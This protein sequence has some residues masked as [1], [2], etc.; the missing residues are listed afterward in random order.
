LPN[1]KKLVLSGS[2][3]ALN[4]LNVTTSV[5][6]ASFTGSFSGSVA[7]PGST[8]QVVYNGGG[9]LSADAG[10]VYSGSRLGIG[11]TSPARSI[12]VES[13]AGTSV[14]IRLNSTGTGGRS[15]SFFSTNNGSGLGGGKF[16]IYDDTAQL[17]R[18]VL[19][20]N[21]NVGFATNSTTV[22]S[23]IQIL[24]A[25]TTSATSTINATDSTGA[26]LL[27]VRDDGNVG[28]G[29]TSPSYK[30]SVNGAIGIEAS[31]EYLYFHSSATVGSNARAKIRAVG[32]GGG[33]GFGGDLRLSSRAS[34]NVWNEDVL[35]IAN[36]GNVG[37]GTIAPAQKLSLAVGGNLSFQNTL[38]GTGTYGAIFSYNDLVNTTTPATAIKFVRDVAIIGPDGAI[39]FD[40]NN[41]ER[42]RITSVG[43]VL[44]GTTADDT[45]NKLQVSG[46]SAFGANVVD[47]AQNAW[48]LFRGVGVS[49]GAGVFGSYGGFVLNSNNA[50]TGGARRYL[51]TN[52]LDVNKFAIIRSVDVS[53]TPT[54][55][56]G[57][58]VLSGF[59]D[60]SISNTGAATFSSSVTAGGFTATDSS[61][62][63]SPIDTG[64]TKA[65][66]SA[67]SIN[68]AALTLVSDSIGRTLRVSA[69]TSGTVIGAFDANINSV[70]IGSNTSSPLVFNTAGSERMRITSGGNVLIGT[71]T[72]GGEKLQVNGTGRF[73]GTLGIRASTTTSAATQ[74][75]VFTAD[76]SGTTRTLVTRT[77]AELRSDIGA[78]AALTNPVTGSG[79]G[80]LV[81]YWVDNNTITGSAGFFYNNSTNTL[82][83]PSLVESSAERFKTNISPLTGSLDKIQEMQGVTFYRDNNPN[84][85]EIGFIADHVAKIYPELIS[86]DDDNQIYGLQYPRITAILVEGIKELTQQIQNQNIF[87]QDL[88]SRIEGLENK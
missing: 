18:I 43:N 9:T 15:Y 33:S 25:G 44:I 41:T 22:S 10:L 42:L 30:L 19:D 3:A 75:P 64:L 37:I 36:T 47:G 23:R 53:T 68:G 56:V 71:T 21:G 1:W 45:I 29:I 5:T 58:A 88:K 81:S 85:Q 49:D 35:T 48:S 2:D 32:A 55:G 59:V 76:P 24:G 65:Y 39:L 12:D 8:T 73:D 16:G 80:S 67:A 28:I 79:S 6:A 57:G 69:N 63:G 38:G 34:N 78:Q 83:V 62:V 46:A 84:H 7:A 54:L 4:S 74:I 77:P 17:G 26:S 51:I 52:A 31:E 72:D 20:S 60:F 50:Y 14:G 40:T 87:I 13:S 61:T 66:F 27:F 86:Y 70:N 82:T 11:N